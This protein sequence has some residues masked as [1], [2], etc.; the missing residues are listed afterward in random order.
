MKHPNTRLQAP[1]K[2]QA[3]NLKSFGDW[4]LEI[5]WSLDVGAW[6]FCIPSFPVETAG[7]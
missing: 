3:S 1:E 4:F 6:S 2:H 5:L 7:K